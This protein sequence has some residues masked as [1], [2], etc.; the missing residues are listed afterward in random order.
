VIHDGWRLAVST[1]P[2]KEEIECRCH[3][4]YRGAGQG[5][6]P[7]RRS[8]TR[9]LHLG[10]NRLGDRKQ[11]LQPRW[12]RQL[13]PG[14]RWLLWILVEATGRALRK[15]HIQRQTE[16]FRQ[17]M[18]CLPLMCK[19]LVV[20]IVVVLGMNH[21]SNLWSVHLQRKWFERTGVGIAPQFKGA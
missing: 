3:I 9:F 1:R 16:Q 5:I 10:D 14:G 7:T 8:H 15:V 13:R 2:G 17:N 6:A 20:R 4:S 21:E 18:E 19:A 11:A 12:Q